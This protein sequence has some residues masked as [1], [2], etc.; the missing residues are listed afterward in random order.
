MNA[1]RERYQSTSTSA[2][3]GGSSTA[4]VR[5]TTANPSSSPAS[6]LRF[7]LGGPDIFCL[8]EKTSAAP[9]TSGMKRFSELV[10]FAKR[11]NSGNSAT[12]KAAT[13]AVARPSSRRPSR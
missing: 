4:V 10:R 8:G 11:M 1:G 9:R 3:S 7:Q 6:R 2:M 5:T 13:A 12:V